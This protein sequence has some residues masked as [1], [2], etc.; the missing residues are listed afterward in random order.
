MLKWFRTIRQF[1]Y[2]ARQGV[3]VFLNAKDEACFKREAGPN[4][5]PVIVVSV[6]KSGTYLFG[7]LLSA[8]GVPALDIHVATYGFQ[9]LRYVS[10]E[11]AINRSGETFVMLP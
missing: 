4:P 6:P 10:K 2:F 8:V 11:F 1:K 3:P 5:N 9:D 7:E